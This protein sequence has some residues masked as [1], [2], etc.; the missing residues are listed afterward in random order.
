MAMLVSSQVQHLFAGLN[1]SIEKAFFR[2]VK[3]QYSCFVKKPLAS[4]CLELVK[5]LVG[6]QTQTTYISNVGY[7]FE[8]SQSTKTTA[9]IIS[10]SNYIGKTCRR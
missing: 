8:Y 10:C 5:T 4:F 7:D 6:Q 9:R 2:P 3:K 1:L